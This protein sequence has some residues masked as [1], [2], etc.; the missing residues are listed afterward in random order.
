MARQRSRVDWLKEGDRNTPFFHA[1]ASARRRTNKIRALVDD[2]GSRCEDLPSIKGLTERF[3]G[4]LFT[5]EPYDDTAVIASIQPKVTDDMNQELSNPYT[6]EEIKSALFQMGLLKPQVR[7]VFRPSSTKPI[8]SSS[9]ANYA[10]LLEVFSRVRIFLKVSA[11]RL[12]F[13]S[14]RSTIQNTSGISD[15]LACVMF[16]TRLRQ[17]YW[18][19]A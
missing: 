1:R 12:L 14:R 13:S 8:R 11:I 5:S 18:P 3:Y 17:R 16:C 7:T 2:D 10:Q 15:R 6:D 9:K 19:T 4:D